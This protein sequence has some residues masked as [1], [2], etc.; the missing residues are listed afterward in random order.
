MYLIV[1]FI[2]DLFFGLVLGKLL[3]KLGIRA[4]GNLSTIQDLFMMTVQGIALY[5][6]QMWQEGIFK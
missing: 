5:G 4:S 2:V 6:Y 1:N 3:H